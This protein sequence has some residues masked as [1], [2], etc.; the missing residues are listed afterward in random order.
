MNLEREIS[1]TSQ[2]LISPQSDSQPTTPTTSYAY[3]ENEKEKKRV[4]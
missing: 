1:A 2:S 3:F 4:D